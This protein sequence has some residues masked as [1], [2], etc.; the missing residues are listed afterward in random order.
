MKAKKTI[1]TIVGIIFAILTVLGIIFGL[2][3]YI[4]NKKFDSYFY[5]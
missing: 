5:N 1:F 4:Q 3:S 2:Y